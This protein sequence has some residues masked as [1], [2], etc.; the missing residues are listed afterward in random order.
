MPPGDL[1]DSALWEQLEWHLWKR[2]MKQER[3]LP[4]RIQ[5][6]LKTQPHHKFQKVPQAHG[7]HSPTSE[8]ESMDGS[9]QATQKTGF[10]DHARKKPGQGFKIPCREDPERST[11]AQ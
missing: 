4:H 3:G 10:K 1:M 7:W 8:S 2:F 6:S 11:R 5:L 9:C